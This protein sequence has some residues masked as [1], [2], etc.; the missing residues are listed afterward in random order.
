MFFLYKNYFISSANI[1]LIKKIINKK[2]YLK[3]KKEAIKDKL[4]SL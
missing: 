4:I 1:I 3:Y 2:Y